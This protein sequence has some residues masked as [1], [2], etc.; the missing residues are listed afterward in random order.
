MEWAAR[1]IG[2]FYVVAGLVALHQM[3]LNWRVELAYA[4]VLPTPANERAGDVLLTIGSALVLVSGLALVLLHRW[5]VPAFLACWCVQA[6]YLLWAQRWRP[7]SSG[8]IARLR[9][10]TLH[11]LSAY[12]AATVAVMALG[13]LGVLDG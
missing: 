2:I 13:R 6:G 11:A 7:P 4:K 5:A 1:A 12:T 10:Q 3:A 9:R 8:E